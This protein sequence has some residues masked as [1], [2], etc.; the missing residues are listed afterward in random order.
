MGSAGAGKV[1]GAEGVVLVERH[2]AI[3]IVTINRPEKL[4]ALNAAVFAALH[5]ILDSLETEPSVKVL[6]FTGRG[7][8]AFVA[9]ADIEQLAKMDAVDAFEQMTSVHR[10]FLRISEFPKP[11]IAM[12]N[13]YAL[14]GG[15]ELALSCDMLVASEAAVFGFPEITLDTLPGWGGTQLAP[16]KMGSNRAREMVLTGNHYSAADCRDFGFINRLVPARQLRAA[17]V[18]LAASLAIRNSFA[19]KMAKSALQQADGLDLSAGMRYET[20]AYT[21]NFSAPHA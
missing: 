8:K 17:A 14:G 1:T 15:F 2:E 18:E 21:A 13:G 7:E 3:A 12:V 16:R 9:G 5:D 4:N 6:I 10:L 11:T 19:L 20:L